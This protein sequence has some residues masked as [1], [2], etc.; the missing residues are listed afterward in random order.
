MA[1]AALRNRML[2]LDPT[3]QQPQKQQQQGGGGVPL[4]LEF[5][6]PILLEDGTLLVYRLSVVHPCDYF[7]RTKRLDG[8]STPPLQ[9]RYVRPVQ[10]IHFHFD[11]CFEHQLGNRLGEHYLRYLLANSLQ[12]PYQMSCG[13]ANPL[14]LLNHNDNNYNAALNQLYP[15]RKQE[16]VLKQLQVHN[17]QPGPVPMDPFS[18]EEWNVHHVCKNCRGAG[19]H[20]P[21]GLHVLYDSIIQ[22]DM[23]R[24]AYNTT[25]VQQHLSSTG[26][27][28]DQAVIHLRLGDVF[29]GKNDQGIG[30]LPHQAY[31]QILHR[32]EKDQDGVAMPLRSIGIVTQPFRKKLARSFDR[33]A[34][35]LRRSWLVAMDLQRYLQ[36]EFPL[37]T[38][39]VHCDETPL[40][41][42]ARLVRAERVAICGPSTFCTNPVLATRGQ[43]FLFRA[44]KHS[45]WAHRVVQLHPE[46]LRS[47]RVP[48]LANNYTA[49]LDE[50]VLLQWLRNQ[51][52]DPIDLSITDPPLIR[53]QPNNNNN[54]DNQDKR[55]TQKQQPKATLNE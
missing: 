37:A 24:L 40:L 53:R 10:R 25:T 48:R 38:V 44:T 23:R 55:P 15:D 39:R 50:P 19:W 16:S 4:S 32:V 51:P 33:N 20:C 21:L 2:Q 8:N 9:Q 41:S 45:P 29:R 14:L 12:L 22:P 1:E 42:M 47:F 34:V 43:G 18:K 6:D 31:A 17:V 5:H 46:R 54:Q 7:V 30:L 27:D 11:D 49:I 52:A 26:Q 13:G 28:D 3:Q 35:L 36:Q